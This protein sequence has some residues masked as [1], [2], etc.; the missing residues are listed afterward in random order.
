[1]V[2]RSKLGRGPAAGLSLVAGLGG[3]LPPANESPAKTN[4]TIASKSR[5]EFNFAS[6]G[7]ETA[8]TR[9]QCGNARA[10]QARYRSAESSNL[11]QSAR[12]AVISC[13]P[14]VEAK[15]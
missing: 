15:G 9:T 10:A 6:P 2:T 7:D 14:L 3:L 1:L 5:S 12:S 8:R 13:Q 11:T 4:S